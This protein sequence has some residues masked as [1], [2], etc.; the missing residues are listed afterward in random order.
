MA[1]TLPVISHSK[2]PHCDI[3]QAPLLLVLL[4]LT[5]LFGA[6]PSPPLDILCP[7]PHYNNSLI[8]ETTGLYI[9][10]M[11]AIFL[12]SQ[13]CEAFTDAVLLLKV[14]LRQR[15]LDQVGGWGSGGVVGGWGTGSLL[16]RDMLIT[17]NSI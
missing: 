14:W 12:A 3:V 4:H 13:T 10:H 17:R 2:H 11:E 9:R 5:P 7:T 8:V 6:H 1:L 16:I 15:Q